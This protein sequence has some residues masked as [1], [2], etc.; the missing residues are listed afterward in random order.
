MEDVKQYSINVDWPQVYNLYNK[1]SKKFPKDKYRMTELLK[2]CPKSTH[3]IIFGQRG[4]GKTT[5]TYVLIMCLFKLFRAQ[6]GYLMRYEQ[7]LRGGLSDDLFSE[8]ELLPYIREI[9]KAEGW[10]RIVWIPYKRGYEKGWYLA[11]D[12]PESGERVTDT[13]PFMRPFALT[14]SD[15]LI[16]LFLFEFLVN[17][18]D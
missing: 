11:K 4:P 3:N 15:G 1:Y 18:T 10:T 12:D 17:R 2:K 9:F 13:I 14:K 6:T 5:S 8:F 7:D 16:I